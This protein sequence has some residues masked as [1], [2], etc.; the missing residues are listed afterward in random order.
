MEVSVDVVLGYCV[1]DV[2]LRFFVGAKRWYE[3]GYDV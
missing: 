1:T 2:R 3:M